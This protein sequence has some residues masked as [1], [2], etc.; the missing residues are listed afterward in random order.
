MLKDS[1]KV[2]ISGDFAGR[3]HF[4]LFSLPESFQVDTEFL[5]QQYKKLQAQFHPDKFASAGDRERR[6]ALQFTSILNEA[7]ETL[8]SP[9]KRASYLLTLHGIDPEENNQAHLGGE[10]LFEQMQLREELEEIAGS[11]S[12]AD[13]ER[14]RHEVEKS[15]AKLLEQF[16]DLYDAAEFAQAK[17]VYNKL[18]FLYK[19]NS[20]VNQVEETLLDY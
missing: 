8:L 11:E 2:A 10:F 5:T 6:L 1:E 16:R 13:L 9:L 14:F 17:P 4:E 7:Y 19:L 15:L 3:N 20:E 12:I 18:Q